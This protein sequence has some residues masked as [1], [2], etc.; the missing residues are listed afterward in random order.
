MMTF[1]NDDVIALLKQKVADL[2]IEVEMYRQ[3]VRQLEKQLSDT[4]VTMNDNATESRADDESVRAEE[5]SG[6]AS[7]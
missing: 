7:S 4:T 3:Y 2:S 6:P 1:T 5:G